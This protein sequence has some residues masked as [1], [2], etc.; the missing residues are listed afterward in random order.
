MGSEGHW[1]SRAGCCFPSFL[2]LGHCIYTWYTVKS[3]YR[4]PPRLGN[5]FCVRIIQIR[6][7][8]NIMMCDKVC[9]VTCK[10]CWFYV[11][12]SNKTDRH[13]ITEILLNVVLKNHNPNPLQVRLCVINK[14]FLHWNFMLCSAYRF[15]HDQ[16]WNRNTLFV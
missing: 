3:V 8:Y 4:K 11:V 15:Q 14:D 7:R 12:S 9:Q 5:N 10:G 16:I 1:T 6:T 13:D 2:C